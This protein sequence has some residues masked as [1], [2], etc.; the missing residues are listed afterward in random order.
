MLRRI[1]ITGRV[2]YSLSSFQLGLYI[3]GYGC[4]GLG[5]HGIEIA[6]ECGFIEFILCIGVKYQEG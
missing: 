5:H 1:V 2:G 6:L 3:E 4:K